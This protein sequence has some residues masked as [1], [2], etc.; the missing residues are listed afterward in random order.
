MLLFGVKRA[1]DALVEK[2]KEP[3]IKVVLKIHI[4]RIHLIEARKIM[5]TEIDDLAL[6]LLCC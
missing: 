4:L 3:F 5:T 2:K 6:Q 1:Y